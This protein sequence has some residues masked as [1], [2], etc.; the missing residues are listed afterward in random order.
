MRVL[1]QLNLTLGLSSWPPGLKR[2]GPWEILKEDD[3]AQRYR[4]NILAL[5]GVVIVAGLAGA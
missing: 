4:R 3:V 1:Y 2:N 5:S